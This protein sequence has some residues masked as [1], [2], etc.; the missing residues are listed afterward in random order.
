M[1]ENLF[2]LNRNK[3]CST[4][5]MYN[6]NLKIVQTFGQENSTVP[7]IFSPEIDFFLVSTQYFIINKPLVGE[8][9]EYN[10]SVTIVNRS[11][12]LVETSFK[13]YEYFDQMELYL[14]KFLITFNH[15]TCFL[16]CYNF[17]GD[18]IGKITLD[19]KL[20]GSQFCVINK[21]LCFILKND[22]LLIF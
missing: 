10:T 21:E 13:I 16:K 6:H 14:D 15:E 5:S 9:D 12:G 22:K 18:L 7:F 8:D 1:G 19:R 11:N 20:K 17:K 4:I 3:K 2:L